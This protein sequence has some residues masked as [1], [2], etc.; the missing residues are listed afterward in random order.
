MKLKLEGQVVPV[1]SSQIYLSS[2]LDYCWL[3]RDRLTLAH[4]PRSSPLPS[5]SLTRDLSCK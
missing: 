1:E 3:E 4:G 5:Y 2:G